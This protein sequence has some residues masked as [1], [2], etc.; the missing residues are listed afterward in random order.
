MTKLQLLQSVSEEQIISFYLL[1]STGQTFDSTKSDNYKSPF[2][3]K[4]DKPSLSFYTDSSNTSNWKFKSHNTGHQGDV[5]QFVADLKK[6]DCK[7]QFQDLI[8][9]IAK[10]FTLNSYAHHLKNPIQV[11]Q[12][13]NK[14]ENKAISYEK[15]FTEAFLSYFA[16]YK[17]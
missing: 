11:K 13:E 4:D 17:I 8:E 5:F 15:D 1:Q 2:A 7:N 3:D 9:A 16:A 12:P 10:D 6:I 14:A